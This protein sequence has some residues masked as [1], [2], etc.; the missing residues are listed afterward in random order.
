M[1][2]FSPTRSLLILAALL[3]SLALASTAN[4]QE[5]PPYSGWVTDLA[6]LVS[7]EKEAELHGLMETYRNGE[8]GHE[9]AVLT[10]PSL[11]GR[12]PEEFSLRVAREWGLGKM[13]TH[14]GALLL[15]AVKERKTRIE[16]GRGLEGSIPDAVASRILRNILAP[17]LRAG[18]YDGAVEDSVR[19][20][21]A[22]AGGDYGP[23]ERAGDRPANTTKDLAIIAGMVIFFL[24]VTHRRRRNP[25][26]LRGGRNSGRGGFGPVII[27]S[28]GRYSGGSGGG[29]GGFGGGGGFSGGGASGGW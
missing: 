18:D 29:F 13:D 16:V 10:V 11:R 19:A 22:A 20:L 17:K 26:R 2:P 6:E 24:V 1:L 15:I 3:C 7:P 12:S 28:P 8:G 5:I 23:L 14:N 27:G 4:A 9:I 25:R 21:H